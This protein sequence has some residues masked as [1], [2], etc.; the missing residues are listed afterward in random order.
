MSKYVTT[1]LY[2]PA[3]SI[4]S[5]HCLSADVYVDACLSER[6]ISPVDVSLPNSLL[7]EIASNWAKRE[8]AI[9]AAIGENSPLIAKAKEV[10]KNAVQL[11]NKITRDAL[12][13]VVSSSQSI[14]VSGYSSFKL[15]RG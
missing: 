8:A 15:G 2:D 11:A 10:E 4:T 13:M 7:S 5:G 9:Q 1:N 3:F 12:G 6:G 14:S